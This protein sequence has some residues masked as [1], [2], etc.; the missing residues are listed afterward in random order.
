LWLVHA[1]AHTSDLWGHDKFDEL[2]TQRKTAGQDIL[3]E[4][5]KTLGDTTFDVQ[6]ELL[7]EPAAEAILN[8]AE[9]RNA[10]LIVLGT[11]GHGSLQGMLVGSVGNKVLQHAHCPVMLVR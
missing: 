7:E 11:R 4:A 8:V 10:D 2:V 5:R 6:E 9:V 3:D 1:F